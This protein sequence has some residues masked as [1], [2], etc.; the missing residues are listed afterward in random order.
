VLGLTRVENEREKKGRGWP[1]IP[2]GIVTRGLVYNGIHLAHVLI[3][4]HTVLRWWGT[5]ES[6]LLGAAAAACRRLHVLIMQ[7]W[8]TAYMNAMTQLAK[9]ERARTFFSSF[10]IQGPTTTKAKKKR[11]SKNLRIWWREIWVFFFF[12]LLDEIKSQCRTKFSFYFF[13]TNELVIDLCRLPLE[14]NF[15]SPRHQNGESF[16][17]GRPPERERKTQKIFPSERKS[18]E[19]INKNRLTHTH[20]ER[21][22]G[23]MR[24]MA[25]RSTNKNA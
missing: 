25:L 8:P 11:K 2:A 5:D 12:F 9:R 16:S 4:S 15:P 22:C 6:S 18:F 20:V 1:R 3:S 23:V 13:K 19:V 14:K 7:I 24:T 17:C 10:S 21:E